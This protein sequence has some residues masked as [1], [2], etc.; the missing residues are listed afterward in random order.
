MLAGNQMTDHDSCLYGSWQLSLHFITG[1]TEE[2]AQHN[3]GYGKEWQ[4]G[5]WSDLKNDMLFFSISQKC[6]INSENEVR[7]GISFVEL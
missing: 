5:K 2:L 1:L 6:V 7:M 3:A 4:T